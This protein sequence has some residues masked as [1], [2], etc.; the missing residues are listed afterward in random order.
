VGTQR[1]LT[2]T[3]PSRILEIGWSQRVN[4]P[5]HDTDLDGGERKLGRLFAHSAYLE[6][7]TGLRDRLKVALSGTPAEGEPAAGEVAD[8][9]KALKG[10]Q[11]VE[12]APVRVRDKPRV[13]A[14][15]RVEPEPPQEPPPKPED[16]PDDPPPPPSF[17]AQVKKSLQPR[18]F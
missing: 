14:R 4:F 16:Q 6:E 13:E 11:V 18:L 15:G 5:D 2:P 8:K 1:T 9:I 7:L 17:R 10:S 3:H 12:A